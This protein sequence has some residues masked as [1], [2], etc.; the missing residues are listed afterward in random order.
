MNVKFCPSDKHVTD[1][2]LKQRMQSQPP[3]QGLHSGDDVS[4]IKG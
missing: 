4:K 1:C 3:E 2:A